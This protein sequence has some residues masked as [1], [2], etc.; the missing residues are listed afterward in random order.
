MVAIWAYSI[1]SG[2]SPS[3]GLVVI[4]GIVFLSLPKMHHR[5]ISKIAHPGITNQIH[6]FILPKS[7]RVSF[8]NDMTLLYNNYCSGSKKRKLRSLSVATGC[9]GASIAE[10]LPIG[11]DRDQGS[12]DI[13]RMKQRRRGS[14]PKPRGSSE[15]YL[16]LYDNSIEIIEPIQYTCSLY[17]HVN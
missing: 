6:I 11:S 15:I 13:D 4:V 2:S 7:L 12:P 14:N 8:R 1:S 16:L 5:M 9:A 17:C 10:I 3:G